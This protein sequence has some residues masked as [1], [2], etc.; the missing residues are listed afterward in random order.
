MF[1]HF[2]RILYQHKQHIVIFGLD[3]IIDYIKLKKK[4]QDEHNYYDV[5]MKFVRKI[6]KIQI[7][8]MKMIGMNLVKEIIQREFY[9][10]L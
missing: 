5:H 6:M 3:I 9:L 8:I 10:S 7:K 4:K 1:D 2:M